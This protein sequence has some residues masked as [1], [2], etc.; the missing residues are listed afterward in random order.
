MST[1]RGSLHCLACPSDLNF[2]LLVLGKIS[3]KKW[4]IE[5]FSSKKTSTSTQ[6]NMYHFSAKRFLWNDNNLFAYLLSLELP[7]FFL[8]TIMPRARDIGTTM[9]KE[10]FA[11]ERRSNYLQRRS[12]RL[13]VI[14]RLYCSLSVCFAFASKKSKKFPFCQKKENGLLVYAC[15]GFR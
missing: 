5:I 8:N 9:F 15:D 13:R 1:Q 2:F 3:W 7:Q 11:F 12:F 6:V 14:K 10:I 4:L